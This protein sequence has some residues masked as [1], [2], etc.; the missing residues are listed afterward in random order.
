MTG[1]TDLQ[2]KKIESLLEAQGILVEAGRMI[3]TKNAK[4]LAAAIKN[5]Q[6]AMEQVALLI[7]DDTEEIVDTANNETVSFKTNVPVWLRWNVEEAAKI[8]AQDDS[9]DARRQ[10]VQSA[11][12]VKIQNELLAKK[13]ASA[14][15]MDSE[16][17]YDYAY[18]YIRDL[19]DDYVVYGMKGVLYQASYT[20]A[21]GVA[22]IGDTTEVKVSYVPVSSYNEAKDVVELSGELVEL[23]ERAVDGNGIANIKVI[24]PGW[25]SSG[26]YSE[27]M[28]KRDGPKIFK[29]GLHMYINHP[30]EEEAKNRPERD[31]ND[32]A[33]VLE[34]DVKWQDNG[35]TG[36]GLYGK[37]KV[38][39]KYK[40][41]ID[42]AAP[43]IGTSIR[44]SGRAVEGE[45]EGKY[46]LIIEG[47][48]DAHSV[49]YVTLPG[50][51][52]E[53]LPLLEAARNDR[54]DQTSLLE[55]KNRELDKDNTVDEAQVKALIEEALKEARETNAALQTRNEELVTQVQEANTNVAR[56]SE[57]MIMRDARE[58]VVAT[59]KGIDLPDMT[60]QRLAESCA[61][62]PPVKDGI[63]DKAAL[64]ESVKAAA[65][66]ELKYLNSVV[67]I[68]EGGR[69]IGVGSTTAK[70]YTAEDNKKD[71]EEAFSEIG[72]SGDALKVAVNGRN[73]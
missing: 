50:R 7:S 57:A 38:F 25:G 27:K 55:N 35:P 21:D 32:L 18:P 47:L 33:G 14:G 5:M 59:L 6:Q 30:T 56:L 37:A 51:G 34:E 24:S 68:A 2:K 4:T 28:L 72:L 1:I 12:R 63:L 16:Y 48:V 26:Y 58:I 73:S 66:E 64:E 9:F 44:A 31:V 49:D 22:S 53:V 67:N 40:D 17:Y 10:A 13:L 20:F 65:V 39:S 19:Y 70:E 41:F 54:R 61:K 45:A 71:L 29:K 8:L 46:G 52:G 36:P 43:Y 60:R 62:N 69:P 23:T 15:S 11:L 42:E 3:S